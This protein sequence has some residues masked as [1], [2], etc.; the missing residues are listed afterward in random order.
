[1]CELARSCDGAAS[2]PRGLAVVEAR[3]PFALQ[4]AMMTVTL[5]GVTWTWLYGSGFDGED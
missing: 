2:S 5:I 4:I 1:M 3:M